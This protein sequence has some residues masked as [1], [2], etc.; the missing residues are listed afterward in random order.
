MQYTRAD[1]PMISCKKQDKNI[2]NAFFTL[3]MRAYLDSPNT[4]I[5]IK[6]WRNFSNFLDIFN[7]PDIDAVIVVHTR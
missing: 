6:E 1:E 2:D 3:S 4:R 5:V 7:V